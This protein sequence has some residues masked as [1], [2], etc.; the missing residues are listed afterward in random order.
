[1]ANAQINKAAYLGSP[2]T[3]AQAMK[4]GTTL[5]RSLSGSSAQSSALNAAT[6]LIRLVSS[7]ACYVEIGSNPTA[8]SSSMYLPANSPEY[9]VVEGGEII[10]ALQAGSGGVL[11]ITQA[12]A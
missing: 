2:N 6:R 9:F 12:G 8:T 11:F 5:T 10:A 3:V 4:I 7:E 1:M